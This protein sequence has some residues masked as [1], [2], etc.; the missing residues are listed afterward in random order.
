MDDIDSHLLLYF[1]HITQ[2][3][4]FL[5]HILSGSLKAFASAALF[6]AN[7]RAVLLVGLFGRQA[8]HL[9]KMDDDVEWVPPLSPGSFFLS[10]SLYVEK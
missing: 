8:N 6:P 10:L 5:L 9:N 4:G 2:L 3:D 1:L 7:V